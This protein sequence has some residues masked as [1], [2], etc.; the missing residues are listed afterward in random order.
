MWLTTSINM[1]DP[2]KAEDLVLSSM[3]GVPS[4]NTTA[5][6]PLPENSL[7]TFRQASVRL[8]S[9]GG[10]TSMISLQEF[11]ELKNRVNQLNREKRLWE[12]TE[13]ALERMKVELENV[14]QENVSLSGVISN[15]RT[16]N[17]SANKRAESDARSREDAEVKL[18]EF[19]MKA[20][21]D[22]QS[23]KLQKDTELVNA[24]AALRSEVSRSLS[25]IEELKADNLRRVQSLEQEFAQT[26]CLLGRRNEENAKLQQDF[27]SLTATHVAITL[28]EKDLLRQVAE[29]TD[30]A[31]KAAS[32]FEE[33]IH[34]FQVLSEEQVLTLRSEVQILTAEGATLAESLRAAMDNHKTA[35]AE[36]DALRI[37][38]RDLSSKLTECE[39]NSTRAA[40]E[41]G[42]KITAVLSDF[43]RTHD[44]AQRSTNLLNEQIA[45]LQDDVRAA[46]SDCMESKKIVSQKEMQLV[47]SE[48][49]VVS[50][51]QHSRT[52]EV[53]IH[54]LV[55]EFEAA[56]SEVVELEERYAHALATNNALEKDTSSEIEIH[57]TKLDK[58]ESEVLRLKLLLSEE[59]KNFNQS[60]ADLR[61]EI[62]GLRAIIVDLKKTRPNQDA[63]RA[64]Q[65]E[66]RAAEAVSRTDRLSEENAELRALLERAQR[67]ADPPQQLPPTSPRPQLAPSAISN[68]AV[69]SPSGENRPKRCRTEEPKRTFAVTGFS[70]AEGKSILDSLR[71]LPN[72]DV[73]ELTPNAPVPAQLTHLISNGQLTVKLLTAL[74]RGCWV[75]DRGFVASSVESGRWLQEKDFGYRHE[76]LPLAK[77]KIAF[78]D[79]FFSSRNYDPACTV[80]KEGGAVAV[81]DPATADIVLCHNRELE[82]ISNGVTWEKFVSM[83]MMK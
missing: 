14:R 27:T 59:R 34:T 42:V 11:D 69:R 65:E 2:F 23:L 8:G 52:L 20:S 41:Y 63:S 28:R 19:M 21:Q 33:R 1:P 61:E 9:V 4:S 17:A 70:A 7:R 36:G 18:T 5:T 35:S 82:S 45:R 39:R 3:R 16:T 30:A 37:Q 74:V 24:E 50:V 32:D 31:K 67:R 56:R 6:A 13:R 44:E 62:S 48:A 29:V 79:G 26:Q 47:R 81:A 51:Q 58:A 77:R 12:D 40:E 53:K 55:S 49:E 76:T 66:A 57:R 71:S 54:Q 83:L 25:C 68:K 78:T 60:D 64:A 72:A 15:L 43:Q 38:V 10:S 80:A 46:R 75:V 22:F 73:V